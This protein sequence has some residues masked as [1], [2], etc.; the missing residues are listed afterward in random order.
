MNLP[1]FFDAAL[2]T[3]EVNTH[4]VLEETT[5]KHVVQVLRMQMG[6]TFYLT[7]GNGLK[8]HV[9]ITAI[10]KKR[11]EVLVG[12]IEKVAQKTSGLSIAIAFTKNASR[13]EWFLEKATELGVLEIIPLQTKRSEK[14]F[15]K[16]E[17]WN[18]ILLT[19]MLQSQQFYLPK[20]HAVQPI[21]Q[22]FKD[23]SFK[24]SQQF[25]AHCIEN[26]EKQSLVNVLNN[27]EDA[28]VLIGPEGDFTPEEIQQALQ[29]SFKPVQLGNTRLRTE[30]AAMAVCSLYNLLD[31]KN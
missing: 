1:I 28:I 2:A 31:E 21:A 7:E 4:M 24:K 25:I 10:Q 19:A 9:T 3:A 17:R 18:T 20:L 26:E 30:T 23:T 11:C 29:A 5:S 22:F 13:N 12:A 15:F 6:D 27:K 8:A 16:E 14:V